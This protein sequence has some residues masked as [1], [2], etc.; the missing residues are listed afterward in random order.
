MGANFLMKNDPLI[1]KKMQQV[2]EINLTLRDRTL[3]CLKAAETQ[4]LHA[5]NL[6]NDYKNTNDNLK[7]QNIKNNIADAL[8]SATGN[9][10]RANNLLQSMLQDIKEKKELYHDP[11]GRDSRLR[12][13]ETT[14][15]VLQRKLLLLAQQFNKTQLD[16]KFTYKEKM[17]RQ[18]MIYDNSI[19]DDAIT[20]L[21]ND[22][23]VF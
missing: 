9:I 18:L 13:L 14:Q 4:I 21:I 7:E 16:I 8:D 19:D 17:K 3:E 12:I 6:R 20:E 2:P 23:N 1:R 22:P 5:A 10:Q 15:S 11:E